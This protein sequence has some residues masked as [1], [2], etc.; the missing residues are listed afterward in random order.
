M[1]LWLDTETRSRV[2]IRQGNVK[3]STA[4]EMTMLQY[5]IGD[6]PVIVIDMLSEKTAHVRAKRVAALQRAIDR[7]DEVWAHQA[8]FDRT[9]CDATKVL[10]IPE[11]KW[12]CTAA[13]A[14]M[15]GLPGGLDKLCT[16]FKVPEYLAKI[17]GK[18]IGAVFWSPRKDGQY[19]TPE[20]QPTAWAQF[21]RYGGRD[22]T[23][24]RAVWKKIPKW[25]ATP[26]MWA[27]WALDYRMNHRGVA[28]D[29][30]LAQ[31]AVDATTKAKRQLA[32]RTAKLSKIQ[33]SGLEGDE[34]AVEA[35]TQRDRLLAYMADFGVTLPD[36]T[37]DT[38]ERRLEDEAL[39][40]HIKELLRIRQKASKASTAKYQRV[41][42]QNV[43]GRLFNLLVFCGAMRTG[44]WAGRTLQPQNLPRPKHDPWDIAHAIA[45][46]SAGTIE[47]YAPD[48]VMGLA[49]SAL[50]GL[51]VAPP[52]RRLVSAD[53]A[54]IEGRFMAWVAGETW[55]LEAFA[56]Y[57][58]KEG[59]D[60]YKVAYARPFGI[61]PNDIADEGDYRR[62]I[63]KVMEL[64]LQYYGGV[65]ALCAMAETYGLRLDELAVTAWGTIPL[66]TKRE[67]Q[68]LWLKAIKRRRTYGL[69]ERTW[70]VCQALVL[71]WRAAH[72]CIVAFWEALDIAI[73]GAIRAP[74]K[75]FRA[76]DRIS[77]DRKGN[78]L[79]IKLPSG[80]YLNYPAPRVKTDG[81]YSSRSFIGVDPY[82]K[83]WGRIPTYSGKDA[84]NVVQG[85]CADII[86]DGLLAADVE[87]YN[88]VLSV[89]D[90]AITEPPDEDR[91]N[92]ADLSRLLVASSS[93]T[94]GLPLAA[95]GK[96]SY[97]Y[98][99]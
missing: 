55:K 28:M 64:A 65:G 26:R 44:R 6:G 80:R 85:G 45:R 25:N 69:P 1:R 39:P 3:Y 57:D 22:V 8:E 30:E 58:R 46:F 81:R 53:L 42:N 87:G 79:R 31:G 76:G 48:D 27:V 75:V 51:I 4:V 19:T 23:A 62:Q 5:A 67:A 35:T 36:L 17:K 40:V 99:K 74:G 95:K 89:H 29:L 96:V 71:L 15:H 34:S 33:A 16:I 78:W 14:R 63:G 60:L 61:D 56:A 54:N 72:P 59:P 49:S 41:L 68:R 66:D 86:M 24:M 2:P 98:S 50:R 84:E 38:V 47:S 21:L 37:A 11:R 9:M 97:R 18:D 91:Y 94:K 7:A 83:Q 70:V 73:K 10:K 77:V 32:A 92:D 52:G 93:W 13:L 88:P 20:M 82:T 43:R 90:E 12:R